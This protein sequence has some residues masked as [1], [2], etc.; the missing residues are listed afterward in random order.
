MISVVKKKWF[1]IYTKSRTEKIAADELISQGIEAYLPVKKTLRKWSDR[2]KWIEAPL[3]PSYVFVRINKWEA[4][5][6]ITTPGV[7]NFVRFSGEPAA[8][9]D[10]QI[11]MVKT[12]IASGHSYYV[13]LEKPILGEKI[14]IE[15]GILKGIEGH[16][17]EIRGKNNIVL[18][19]AAINQYLVIEN[20]FENDETEKD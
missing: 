9:P 7:V 2:K 19:I 11:R 16:I 20:V 18:E 6:T 5:K 10:K 8:I 17:V 14:I 15:Y 12:I 4:A 1:A 3:F 13:E